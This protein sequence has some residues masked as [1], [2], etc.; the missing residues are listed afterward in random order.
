MKSLVKAT[1]VAKKAADNGDSI[2]SPIDF[3]KQCSDRFVELTESPGREEVDTLRKRPAFSLFGGDAK[4]N[5]TD[6]MYRIIELLTHPADGVGPLPKA[7]EELQFIWAAE[8][9][10]MKPVNLKKVPES[11]E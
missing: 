9:G 1:N 6:A 4:A 7:A 2:P 3:A 5:T 11:D 8:N 10:S